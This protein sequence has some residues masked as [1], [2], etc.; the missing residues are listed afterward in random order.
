MTNNK[1]LIDEFLE[2]VQ[3]DSPT[4]KEGKIAKVLVNKLEEIGLTV[5]IDDAAAKTGSETGN[6]IARLKGTKEGKKILFSSHMD[7]VSP[8]IGVKPIIDEDTGIIKSDG[9]TILGSDDKAG[10][11]AILEGLRYIKENNIDHTDIT[12][13]FSIWEEGGLFGAKSLDYSK[14]DVDY[15]FVLDS[16][17]SPGEIIVKAPGQDRIEVKIIGKPAH[18]GLQPED[19]I[20][21]M[22]VASKAI[23]NMNLL[24]IDEETTANIG[25]VKG[26]VATNIV[27]PEM[28]II[29]EARSLDESKLDVQTKHMIDT[30]KNAAEEFGAKIE[31]DTKRMYSPL[32]IDDNDDIVEFTKRAFANINIEG[33]TASTGGGSDT[34]ILNKNGIK[35]VNLGIGMKKAHTLDEYIAIED[36]INSA[37]AVVEII[38]QA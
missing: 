11:A 2:L 20:S 3:I 19:G 4:S 35:A 5:E 31:V 12:V 22:M 37:K 15:G 16:G 34:N 8:G 24:R 13:V 30:F 26:G 6:V 14:L 10:I 9:T 17:G 27:M 38:K 23:N 25:I 1:R 36:L 21:A 32:N 18:A 28:E 29:A 7:T 33:K